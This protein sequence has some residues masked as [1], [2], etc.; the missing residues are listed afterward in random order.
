[1]DKYRRTATVPIRVRFWVEGVLTNVTTHNI[2]IKDPSGQLVEDEQPMGYSSPGV[3]T[4][5]YTSEA[6]AVLGKYTAH[7]FLAKDSYTDVPEYI[8]EIV[9]EVT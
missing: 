4:Y 9:E 6:T 8:F 5:D 2:S 1:M 7:A 3:Y